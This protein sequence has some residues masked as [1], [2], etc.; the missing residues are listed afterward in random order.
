M[1][2]QSGMNFS[3]HMAILSGNTDLL[4]KAK[5]EKRIA[6]LEGERKS[7]N[8]GRRESEFKLEGKQSEYDGNA[9][10]IR[11]MTEDWE[12]FTAKAKTDKEGKHVNAF[13]LVDSEKSVPSSTSQ[14]A[15]EKAIGKRL[16]EIAKNATTGGRY[17]QI[18]EI[19][20]FKVQVISEETLDNGLPL[21]KFGC[22]RQNE[23]APLLS[24]AQTFVDNRFVVEGNYKYTYNNGHIAMSDPLLAA[25]NFLNALEKIPSVI[26]QYEKKNETLSKEIE[27]LTAITAKT[28]KKEDEQKQLKSELS[29]LERKIQLELAPK[30]ERQVRT[31]SKEETRQNGSPY[32]EWQR[33]DEPQL[34]K[35]VL[36]HS[37]CTRGAAQQTPHRQ[38]QI[39][40]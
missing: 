11:G 9:E 18:G 31:S 22:T 38:W 34:K 8:K 32:E 24:F 36:Q 20:G 14:K 2:E 6:S 10:K 21:D 16:Q 23:Q 30:E 26:A 35:E 15:D 3:E 5:L 37:G 1:D 4:D 29:A 19:Y 13:R 28:W 27:Q 12:K 7:F 25:T 17:R 33:K 40:R 39:R